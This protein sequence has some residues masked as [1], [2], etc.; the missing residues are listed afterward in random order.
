MAPVGAGGLGA[1]AVARGVAVTATRVTGA[2]VRVGV[3]V[4]VGATVAVAATVGL[5]GTVGDASAAGVSVASAMTV[6]EGGRGV[7]VG[8]TA[9][10]AGTTSETSK[11]IAPR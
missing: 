4:A 11:S 2:A 6:G 7:G 8:L 1:V 10:H 9:P 5:G 3:I